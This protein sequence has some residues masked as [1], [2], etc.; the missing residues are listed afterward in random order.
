M[1]VQEKKEKIFQQ[2]QKIDDS[3]LIEHLH[4]LIEAE[5]KTKQSEPYVLSEEE[6]KAIHRAE[7]DIKNNKLLSHEKAGEQIRKWL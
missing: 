1:T 5:M 4:Q 3:D 6:E 2:I 7:K